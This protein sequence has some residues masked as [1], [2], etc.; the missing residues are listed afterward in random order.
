MFAPRV[1][2]ALTLIEDGLYRTRRFRKPSYVGDP[3]NAVR[4]FNEKEVDELIVLDI[5]PLHEWKEERLELLEQMAAEAFMPMALG[6]CISREEHVERAFQ[7][8][9]DKVVINS[10]AIDDIA[11]IET[12]CGRFGGQSIVVSIDVG[13]KLFGGRTVFTNLGRKA[14]G[15]DPVDHALHCEKAGAG[16]IIIR[17][18][19]HDGL[20]QGFDLDLV[21]RVSEAVSV[22]VVATGG[23]GSAEHLAAGL[24]AGAHSVSAGSM[25]VYHGPHRAVLINYLD[26]Q[27]ISKVLDR[28]TRQ[29]LH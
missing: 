26:A 24:A 22:P 5:T 2:P 29:K 3:L 10:A 25:F 18:I 16:E 14:A 19:E 27:E 6:G 8:G 12:L 20:M 23:A 1:I 11:L 4:I 21:S 28:A 15:I 13:K 9:Y 7:M 17:S